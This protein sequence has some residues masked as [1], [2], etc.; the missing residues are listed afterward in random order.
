MRRTGMHLATSRCMNRAL[1]DAALLVVACVV[2]GIAPG[3]GH[4]DERERKVSIEVSPISPFLRIYAVQIG[5]AISTNTELIAGPA[6]MNIQY[7]FGETNAPALILGARQ[8]LWRTLHVEYQ[9]WPVYDWFWESQE[10]RT[11]ESFDLWNEAR[12]GYRID[13]ALRGHPVYVNPQVAFGF[14]LY[15]SNK[16]ESFRMAEEDNRY[17]YA[18]LVFVGTKL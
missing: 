18:P 14:G 6:Y 11:Y 16:P 8:Y 7:D 15:A 10:Q 17:F 5:Y 12:A 2:I 1:R 9:I 4:A 3:D 13:F